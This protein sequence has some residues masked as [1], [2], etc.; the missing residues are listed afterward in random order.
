MSGR[1]GQCAACSHA[2]ARE[3]NLALARG[4]PIAEVARTFGVS[5]GIITRHA[6]EHVPKTLA[7]AQERLALADSDALARTFNDLYAKAHELL[8][9]CEQE[10]DTRGA[11]VALREVVAIVDIG[12]RVAQTVAEATRRSP[13]QINIRIFYDQLTDARVARDGPGHARPKP[14]DEPQE[15]DEPPKKLIN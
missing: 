11:I 14:I 6:R 3:I 2:E 5:Y 7:L 12:A 9:R 4:T 10:G 13:G 8:A 1:E 15:P